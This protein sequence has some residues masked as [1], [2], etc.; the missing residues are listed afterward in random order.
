MSN[1]QQVKY[2][3]NC[4]HFI[5]HKYDLTLSTCAVTFRAITLVVQEPPRNQYCEVSRGANQRCGPTGILY[6]EAQEPQQS[7]ES[8][9][10]SLAE[11][12]K[13]HS[14]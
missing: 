1:V 5:P 13:I 9:I 10:A 6:E 7:R 3:G 8:Q 4:K 11:I 2:C 12:R 14:L